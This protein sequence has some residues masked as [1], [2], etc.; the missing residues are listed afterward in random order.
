MN[1]SAKMVATGALALGLAIATSASFAAKPE[2]AKAESSGKL[3]QRAEQ[4][5]T[6][7]Q[8]AGKSSVV[9]LIAVRPGATTQAVSGISRLGGR[10]D[11]RDDGLGYIR[12]SVPVGQVKAVAALGSVQLVEVDELVPLPDPRPEGIAPLVPQVPPVG[13]DSS[14]QSVPADRRDRR[15]PVHRCT[16]DVGWPRRHDR[17]RRSRHHARSPEPAH[18]L[19]RRK[20]DRGLGD[21]HRSV[22]RRRP[23][24]ARHERSGVGRPIHLQRPHIYSAERGRLPHCPVQRARSAARRRTGQRRQSR[25]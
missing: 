22:H 9:L 24:V 4:L 25:R 21:R 16:S 14:Q 6:E 10:I 11:Y 15:R 5:L 18:H 19:D 17:R 8:Q 2:A 20:K 23:D 1:V 3:S 12:A 7:A 13:S